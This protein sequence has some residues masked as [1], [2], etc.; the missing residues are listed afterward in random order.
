MTV[1]LIENGILLQDLSGYTTV[2]QSLSGIAEARAFVA[3]Q[4]G[5]GNLLILTDLSSSAFNQTVVDAMRDMSAQY[6]PW[7]KASALVGLTPIMRVIGKAIMAM[8]RRDIRICATRDEALAYL[9]AAAGRQA[10]AG[11]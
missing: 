2:E 11:T 9:R 3:K 6:R 7:V 5:K 8:T 1:R 10:K 4:P